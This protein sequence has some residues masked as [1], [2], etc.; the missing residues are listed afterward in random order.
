MDT[1]TSR[2]LV[3]LGAIV[4][5]VGLLTVV[6]TALDQWDH[7]ADQQRALDDAVA[8]HQADQRRELAALRICGPNAAPQWDSPTELRCLSN[9]HKVRRHVV[10]QVAP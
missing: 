2:R 5:I 9:G 10:A 6:G 8:Q 1:N 7:L 4:G 3:N